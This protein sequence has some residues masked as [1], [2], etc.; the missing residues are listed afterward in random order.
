MWSD[1]EP[2]RALVQ[3]N[4]GRVPFEEPGLCAFWPHDTPEKREKKFCLGRYRQDFSLLGNP[5][6]LE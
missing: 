5:A 1:S 3:T 6:H 4:N 2:L